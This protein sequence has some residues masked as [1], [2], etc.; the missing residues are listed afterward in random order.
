MANPFPPSFSRYVA[1][2]AEA[3]RS[4]FVDFKEGKKTLRV[5]RPGFSRGSPSNDWG[6]AFQEFR[7]QIQKFTGSRPVEMTECNFSTSTP[8][9]RVASNIVLMST[10]QHYFEYSMLCGCGLPSVELLGEV[11]WIG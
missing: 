11:I 4:K 3:L 10:M 5:V 8:A 7:E 2:H 9:D 1:Q 6:D